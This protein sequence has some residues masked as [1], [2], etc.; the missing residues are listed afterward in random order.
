MEQAGLKQAC[1]ICGSIPERCFVRGIFI[2]GRYMCSRCEQ[3]I[4]EIGMDDWLYPIIQERLKI[5]WVNENSYPQF[6]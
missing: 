1:L 3:E 2:R 4:T 5:I 6:S